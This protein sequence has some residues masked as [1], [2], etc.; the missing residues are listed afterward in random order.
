YQPTVWAY[1]ARD[2][3]SVA[4]GTRQMWEVRPYG[5]WRLP[6]QIQNEKV[7]GAAYDP[8]T[9]RIFVLEGWRDAEY[10][11]RVHVLRIRNGATAPTDPQ[12][13]PVDAVV[14]DWGPWTPTG[15]WSVCVEPGTQ[16]RGEE[17]TRTVVT[18]AQ[19]GGSTPHL[20]ETRVA[21]R[22]CS[23]PEPE[24]E[25]EPEPCACTGE[26]G[27]QGPAGPQGPRGEPGPP[28]RDGASVDID[29]LRAL[30]REEIRRI[31]EAAREAVE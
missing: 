12:P 31:L 14:S 18:P 17:R 23:L 2:L 20:R 19:H 21:S 16:T 1:D 24:P 27:P 29:A 6:S 28:G 30:I 3:A 8:A 5:M 4:A 15:D 25:P 7:S 26:P 22:A 10:R 11:G 13:Q 9:G